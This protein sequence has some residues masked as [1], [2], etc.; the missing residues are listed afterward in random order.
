MLCTQLWICWLHRLCA[1]TDDL[2]SDAGLVA[3]EGCD[4][5]HVA[6]CANP[7][8]L[9]LTVSG[10]RSRMGG[11]AGAK[12]LK[13]NVWVIK[14]RMMVHNTWII[15]LIKYTWNCKFCPLDSSLI[16]PCHSFDSDAFCGWQWKEPYRQCRNCRLHQAPSL[17]GLHRA[18]EKLWV[19]SWLLKSHQDICC[20]ENET[21]W[22]LECTLQGFFWPS[23]WPSQAL[24]ATSDEEMV[25]WQRTQSSS[26]AL[27]RTGPA[28]R[29]RRRRKMID[30]WQNCRICC[31]LNKK[32][33]LQYIDPRCSFTFLLFIVVTLLTF[34]C[35][36]FKQS[37]EDAA[38]VTCIVG[39]QLICNTFITPKD[40]TDISTRRDDVMEGEWQT[41]GTLLPDMQTKRRWMRSLLLWKR[42]R[43][44]FLAAIL[45]SCK[46]RWV[47]WWSKSSD[48][49]E[50]GV[51][52][53]TGLNGG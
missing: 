45:A 37:L 28:E 41:E 4:V 23:N 44:L 42:D 34:G 31:F 38:Q 39:L 19:Q 18:D 2:G 48:I 12:N 47:S 46:A 35:H 33:H 15:S 27:S 20:T 1:F 9:H 51:R 21:D 5:K 16:I 3:V 50:L 7:D 49:P 40:V 26:T 36:D 25:S 52:L 17:E 43:I 10:Q 13:C 14:Q 53:L 22:S 29:H 24:A 32:K 11:A 6:V 8:W 30:C